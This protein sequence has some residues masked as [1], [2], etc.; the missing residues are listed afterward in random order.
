MIND[1]IFYPFIK[2]FRKKGF[3]LSLSLYRTNKPS[4]PF[5]GTPLKGAHLNGG[6]TRSICALFWILFILSAPNSKLAVGQDFPGNGST[7]G[8]RVSLPAELE[9]LLAA[10]GVPQTLE[11]LRVLEKQQQR[12][13]NLAAKCTVSVQIGS[14]QGCGVIVS[15]SGYI[16]TAAHVAMRPNKTAVIK[17]S[18]GRIVTA[19]TR[20]LY[21]SVD[22]GLIKINEGQ[23][24]GAGWPHAT[25]GDSNNLK[26]GMWCIA[27]G[28]P[29]GYD[30]GRGPVTRVGRILA[31]ENDKIVTDC[32]LIGGDSGGPLFDIEGRLI[33]VHSRIGNDVADNLHIPINHYDVNWKRLAAG[34]SWGY[35]DGF[36]PMLGVS[37]N[38]STGVAEVLKVAPGSPADDADIRVGDT[39]QRFGDVPITDF[40]SLT[41]AVSDTMPGERVEVWLRRNNQ[42]LRK[43][44]E[45]GRVE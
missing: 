10:G 1:F 6:I 13:A 27:S 25:L 30:R 2:T 22:A 45:I 19:T 24:G 4:P 42:S 7:A 29:G 26:P 38:Q 33:A 31:V 14:A 37:G 34:E 40:H 9:P 8:T 20:G 16:L 5:A 43:V 17:L 11:Q 36:K 41:K 12:V 21:R 28:H 35:L 39:I 23:D 44:V 32:A 18:D 15:D 3:R